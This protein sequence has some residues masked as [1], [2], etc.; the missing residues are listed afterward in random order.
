MKA[1]TLHKQEDNL[2]DFIFESTITDKNVCNYLIDQYHM[3][4]HHQGRV[5]R[6]DTEN[7]VNTN[8]KVA[9]QSFVEP[10]HASYQTIY[11]CIDKTIKSLPYGLT[12]PYDMT[13]TEYSI[14]SL[15]HI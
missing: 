15:I 10:D 5:S 8:M 6:D 7:F 3:M 2:N 9:E 13:S 4:E 11:E 1:F 14:L 12:I